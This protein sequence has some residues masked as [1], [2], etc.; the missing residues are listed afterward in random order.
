MKKT[1]RV[2]NENDFQKWCEKKGLTP[3]NVYDLLKKRWPCIKFQ[4]QSVNL[5]Y[6][7]L[8]NIDPKNAPFIKELSNGELTLESLLYPP[9]RMEKINKILNSGSDKNI[10]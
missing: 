7:G 3:K 5:W 10:N 2:I 1:Y 8:R 6:A 4:Q 9:N